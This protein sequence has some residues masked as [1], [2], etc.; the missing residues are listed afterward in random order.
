MKQH[1]LVDSVGTAFSR[2]QFADPFAPP[3]ALTGPF[4]NVGF[5]AGR[6]YGG[7]VDVSFGSGGVIQRTAT[8]GLG[9]GGFRGAGTLTFTSVTPACR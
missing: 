2:L 8:L 9:V 7:G 4:V 3:A 6:G 1:L 5:G